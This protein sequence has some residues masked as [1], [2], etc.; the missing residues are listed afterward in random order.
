MIE[1]HKIEFLKNIQLFSS[2]TDEELRQI[3][4][5]IVIKRFK[6]NETVLYEEDTNEFMYIVLSGK[7]KVMRTTEDGKE[8]ILAMRQP[9][10][11][12]GEIS[13][14]DG[15][16][17]PATVIATEDS[18]IAII[19]KNAFYTILFNHNNVLKKFLQIL[20]SRLRDSWERIQLLNLNNA[21][22]R[23]KMLFLNLSDEYGEKTPEGVT[24]NIKLTH[25]NISD[26]TGMTRET[27]TRIIDKWQKNGEITVLKNKFIR[28]SPDFLQK[29]LKVEIS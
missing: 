12:F 14:I 29:D 8:I 7:V 13:L 23:I 17:T 2:L 28:L 5:R 3:I 6:K 20:C 15:K 27:V 11:F 25:Q 16:T 1:K 19:S 26:M 21:S 9:G 24:L 22:Q 18:I 4:N 10:N